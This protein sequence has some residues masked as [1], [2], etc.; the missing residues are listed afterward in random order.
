MPNNKTLLL[1]NAVVFALLPGVLAPAV[2]VASIEAQAVRGIVRAQSEIVISSELVARISKL[3]FRTGDAFRKGDILVAFDC[4]RYE[5]DLKSSEA[6]ARAQNLTY[7]QNK[8]LVSRGAA[9]RNDLAISEAKYEQAMAA[10]E[11]LKVRLD[12]CRI[13]APF[14]GRVA[15]RHVDVHEL[16][17]ANAP[18]LKIVKDGALDIDLI[19]P[20]QW[21]TWLRV[22]QPFS[23]EVDETRT[24]HEA[25]IVRLG[26][27]VDPISRTAKITGRFARPTPTVRPGMSGVT[28]LSPSQR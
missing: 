27:I 17:T 21:L 18:L 23:F 3:P 8:Q 16:P 2:A 10:V 9:G 28:T 19:V 7:V 22:G 12:Q 6:E 4:R 20:S 11:S 1:L 26:A 14:N 5:A 25:R 24:R 13:V 15:E